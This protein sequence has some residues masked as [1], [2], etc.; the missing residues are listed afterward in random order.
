ML[1]VFTISTEVLMYT[2]SAA[3]IA[4]LPALAFAAPSYNCKQTNQIAEQVICGSQE[5][6]NLDLLIARQYRIA[7]SKANSENEK[8]SLRHAQ[9]VWVS[10]R[11]ECEYSFDC[12]KNE[13][14]ERLN[15]LKPTES[16]VF[17]WGGVL[18]QLPS[19]E[20]DQVGST[21]ERQPIV[22][23]QET[24]TYWNG[25]PWFKVSASGKIAYQWGG[26]I[27]DIR[28]PKKTFCEEGW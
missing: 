16:V 13:S 19:L 20:S 24:S 5:L 15:I 26:I 14:S 9:R 2:Y 10:K 17:S 1:G 12:L 4:L 22:I 28:R 11:N 18:R 27:C 3:A 8:Q 7:L 25:R 21:Y 6:S 23:L